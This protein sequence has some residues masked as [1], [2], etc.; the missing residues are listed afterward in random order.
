M[1][2]TLI[3][4]IAWEPPYAVGVSPPPQ[5]KDK[6]TQKNAPV[7]DLKEGMITYEFSHV[8]TSQGSEKNYKGRKSMREKIEDLGGRS[9]RPTQINAEAFIPKTFISNEHIVSYRLQLLA[10]QLCKKPGLPT[11]EVPVSQ[12]SR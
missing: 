1:V 4:R 12:S 3:Q 6:T 2:T 10:I 9:G 5:K 7:D 11:H 8:I